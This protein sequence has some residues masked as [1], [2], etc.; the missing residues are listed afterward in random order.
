MANGQGGEGRTHRGFRLAAQSARLLAR[1]PELLILVFVGMIASL[2]ISLGLFVLI[3]GHLPTWQDF[4]GVRYLWVM[5]IFAA[6]SLV[7]TFTNAVV[8][9]MA[10]TRL[11]GGEPTLRDGLRLTAA[12]FPK[13]LRWWFLSVVVGFLLHAVLARLRLAGRV[14]SLTLGLTW[15]LATLFVVPV[16]LYEPVGALEAVGRS[17][18][19][20]KQRWGEEVAGTSSIGL[21]VLV[22]VLPVQILLLVGAVALGVPPKYLFVLWMVLF[23]AIMVPVSAVSIVFNAALYRYAVSGAAIGPFDEGDLENAYAYKP[24]RVRHLFGRNR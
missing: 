10:N 4:R 2:A 21:A 11:E 19:L 7:P 18:S 5:P 14:A 16:L 13:L 23:S 24:N 3:F 12:T 15:Y 17:A 6:G 8:V 1:D 20:F 22:V 9:G